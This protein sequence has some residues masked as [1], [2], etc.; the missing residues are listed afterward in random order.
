M[1]R[2]NSNHITSL[3]LFLGPLACILLANSRLEW[4]LIAMVVG[5][6]TDAIDGFVARNG[7]GVSEWGK[8]YDPL[9][10]AIFNMSI[11]AGFLV[12]GWIPAYLLVLFVGRDIATSYMRAGL[13]SGSFIMA[14]RISGKVKMVAQAVA[15]IGA[16]FLYICIGKNPFGPALVWVAAFITAISLIDYGQDFLRRARKTGLFGR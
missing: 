13:A 7:R 14:A 15:Q 11:W 16:V 2:I 8:L 1:H 12:L 3:R 4:A 6:L 10:D 9:C 5:E